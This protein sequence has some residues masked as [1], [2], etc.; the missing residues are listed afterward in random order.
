MTSVLIY[1]AAAVAVAG[2]DR[3]YAPVAAGVAA[4]CIALIGFDRVYDG[5]HW[6]SDVLGG[7]VIGS[8]LLI[9][10]FALPRLLA[11]PS[12]RWTSG[13]ARTRLDRWRSPNDLSST[14]RT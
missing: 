2:C 10:V 1:G 6:P 4:I 9:A 11:A 12:A 5:A 14:S 7:V 13:R 8:V 3:R